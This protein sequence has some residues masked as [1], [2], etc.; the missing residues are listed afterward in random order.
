MTTSASW[1]FSLTAAQIIQAAYE[2]IGMLA[3]GVAPSSADSALALSRL[4]MLVKQH[5]G[6]TDGT[7]GIPIYTRQRVVVPLVYLQQNYLIGPNTTDSNSSTQ[8]GRTTISADEAAAQTVLSITSNTDITSY[9]G[10]TLTMT[11]GD[12]IGIQLNDSTIQWT[13]I[14]GTPGLT[15]TV[16]NAL[17]AAASAGKYVWWYTSKAQRFPILEFAA[18][19][20]TNFNDTQLAVYTQVQEYESNVSKFADGTPTS[21]LV[22]PLRLN[23]RITLNSQ[24]TDTSKQLYLTVLYPSE[25]YDATTNDIAF[26][27]EGLRFLSWELAFALAPSVGRWTAE[28]DANHKDARAMWYNLNAENTVVYF[29]PNFPYA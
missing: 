24:P 12:N 2:D 6:R 10:T 29:Q 14:S 9:T 1:D 26:P 4:N 8:M 16:N 18:L 11:N 23:T 25:D 28:M 19:R 22:E 3:P 15:A 17:T 13:T 5:Q 20:D 7:A 21:I 27:Q